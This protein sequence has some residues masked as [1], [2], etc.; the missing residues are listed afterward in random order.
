[1]DALNSWQL[2]RAL[3]R[4]TGKPSAASFKHVS[5]AARPSP[6]RSATRTAAPSSPRASFRPSRTAYA[7]AR[8]AD[9]LCSYGDWAALSD[10]CD[11]ETARLLLPEVSD[12][13]IAPGYTAEALEILR[14]KRKGTTTSC[15]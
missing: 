10:V 6:G 11:A 2:V 14:R 12:G 9:R 7:R 15:A 4:A 13:I 3:K 1:M 8:G 5:P